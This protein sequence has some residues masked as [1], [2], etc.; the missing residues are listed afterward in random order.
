METE[1]QS[2]FSEDNQLDTSSDEDHNNDDNKD[3]ELLEQ[4]IV[5]RDSK[6]S[7]GIDIDRNLKIRRL[8]TQNAFEFRAEGRDRSYGKPTE[9]PCLRLKNSWRSCPTAC[10]M[11]VLLVTS[12]EEKKAPRE[13]IKGYVPH[14]PSLSKSISP[15]NRLL[16]ETRT[17]RRKGQK[18]EYPSKT[19]TE[20]TAKAPSTPDRLSELHREVSAE[21][22]E[23]VSNE[24]SVMMGGARG[25]TLHTLTVHERIRK[26][27]FL[28]H[29]KDLRKKYK[30]AKKNYYD[31]KSPENL[32]TRL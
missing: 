31:D 13:P 7:L 15:R 2:G 12:I 27:H 32:R 11:S 6:G 25:G 28:R 24:L 22:F 5:A 29:A 8:N 3:F 18:N 1:R 26:L 19:T 16:L 9:F 4:I 21:T 30:I 10:H 17:G 14:S 23:P 20:T